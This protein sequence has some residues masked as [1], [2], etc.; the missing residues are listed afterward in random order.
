VEEKLGTVT[1]Q[2]PGE[3]EE[4]KRKDKET[5]DRRKVRVIPSLVLKR[6]VNSHPGTKICRKKE[7]LLGV[8]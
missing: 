4:A 2:G 6:C 1:L 7:G 3:K 5:A 8:G